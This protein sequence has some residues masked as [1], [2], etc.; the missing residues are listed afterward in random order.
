MALRASA[1]DISF[2]TLPEALGFLAAKL[3]PRA[4][5]SRACRR[6]EGLKRRGYIITLN[7]KIRFQEALKPYSV[8]NRIFEII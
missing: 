6:I 8:L 4:C 2:V 3:D 7:K 1:T 5:G